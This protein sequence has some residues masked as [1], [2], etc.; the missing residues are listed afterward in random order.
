MRTPVGDNHMTEREKLVLL[1]ALCELMNLKAEP[2]KVHG[3][4][5]DAEDRVDLYLQAINPDWPNP[6]Q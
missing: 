4:I 1:V 5:Q 2:G 3:A 6:P